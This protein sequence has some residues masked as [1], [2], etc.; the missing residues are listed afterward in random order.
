[1]IYELIIDDEALK[2]LRGWNS[3]VILDTGGK[4]FEV[5][6]KR[7]SKSQQATNAVTAFEAAPIGYSL[8][9]TGG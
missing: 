1:M 9:W 7:I 6:S 2:Q 4:A 8:D 3:A 5:L